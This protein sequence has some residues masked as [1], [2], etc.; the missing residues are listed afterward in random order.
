VKSDYYAGDGVTYV[1]GGNGVKAS[2]FTVEPSVSYPS[3]TERVFLLGGYYENCD[4]VAVLNAKYVYEANSVLNGMGKRGFNISP[5]CNNVHIYGGSVRGGASAVINF[6]LGCTQCS[7]GGKFI[8]PQGYD[9][10][11]GESTALRVFQGCRDIAFYDIRGKG[12]AIRSLWI[13]GCSDVTFDNVKLDANTQSETVNC[14]E[15]DA[16]LGGNTNS[17][18]VSG[19]RIRN[20]QFA[21][22]YAYAQNMTTG[23]AT[24]ANDGIRLRSV[25]FSETVAATMASF[26]VSPAVQDTF[27]IVNCEFATA[28]FITLTPAH[29]KGNKNNTFAGDYLASSFVANRITTDTLPDDCPVGVTQSIINGTT[30]APDTN[31]QGVLETIKSTSN[32]G[33]RKFIVQ[34]YYP[35]NNAG[36]EYKTV[37]VRRGLSASNAWS[38]WSAVT[39]S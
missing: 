2:D 26:L 3:T 22:K 33:F 32:T 35:A 24:Y 25:I 38:A 4:R 15:I 5:T 31:K 16:G 19:I 36:T 30:S 14:I 6:T 29:A 34:R 18:V 23:T 20:S 8:D 12:G 27:S 39:G 21:G 37:Y 11:S 17:W 9:S 1:S 13:V 10:L 28:S 7:A